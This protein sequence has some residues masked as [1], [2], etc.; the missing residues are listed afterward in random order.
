MLNISEGLKKQTTKTDSYGR[1]AYAKP[2]SSM[3]I[4]IRLSHLATYDNK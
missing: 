4:I 2:D 3:N 1:A